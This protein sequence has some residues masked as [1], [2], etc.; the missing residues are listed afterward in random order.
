MNSKTNLSRRS[1]VVSTIG[2]S[3]AAAT[4]CLAGCDSRSGIDRQLSFS[5]L[6]AALGELTQLEAAKKLDSS[7]TWNWAQTLDHCSQSI[8][9]SMSGFPQPKPAIFQRTV[10]SAAFGYFAW[11]GHMTHDLAEPIPGA[12]S[13]SPDS[14]PEVAL[15]RLRASIAGFQQWPKTLKPHFA[16][17]ELD[18]KRY[19][20]AH[21]MHLAS[22]LSQFRAA[23]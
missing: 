11:R 1:I 8:E 4:G 21:A 10:G 14:A 13:L 3:S 15:A 20:L 7:S 2:L 5:S 23:S 22:H 18:K 6:D 12:P 19:E 16:Y 9:Y 17:G